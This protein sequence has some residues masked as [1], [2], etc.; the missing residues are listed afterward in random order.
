VFVFLLQLLGE[1]PSSGTSKAS[2]R[3]LHVPTK[4]PSMGWV[5]ERDANSSDEEKLTEKIAGR[6]S[7]LLYA[8]SSHKTIPV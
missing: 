6:R 3:H 4:K 7:P 2:G 5:N 1:L 8:S